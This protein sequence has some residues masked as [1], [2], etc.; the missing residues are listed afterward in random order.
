MRL[1]LTF[2]EQHSFGDLLIL[3]FFVTIAATVTGWII[4]AAIRQRGFGVIGNSILIILGVVVGWVAAENEGIAMTLPESRRILIFSTAASA[5][6][7]LTLCGF[8]ARTSVT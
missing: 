3:S 4:D 1:V 2:I 7:L 8:K 6:I 5:A